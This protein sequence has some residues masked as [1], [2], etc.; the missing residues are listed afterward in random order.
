MKTCLALATG[1]VLALGTAAYAADAPTA[2]PPEDDW[3]QNHPGVELGTLTCDYV[4]GT[5]FI[6]GSSH[7]LA[8]SFTS[9]S[10]KRVEKYHG[11]INSFGIDLG[12][13]TSG[14]LIWGVLAP[15][16]NVKPGA[17]SGY[18]GGVSAG[19][20][21]GAGG[22]VNV[23]IGGLNR[24]IALQPLSVQGQTGLNISAGISGLTLKSI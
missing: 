8:C 5:S 19:V 24:S 18:Y 6:I 20:T 9:A 1:A 23:L 14:R 12:P 4:Q 13:V 16:A 15:K 21:L 11:S 3:N 17:L 2:P 7:D 10:G 22:Q